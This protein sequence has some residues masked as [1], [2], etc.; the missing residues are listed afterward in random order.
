MPANK[1]KNMPSLQDE[2]S[3]KNVKTEENGNNAILVEEEEEDDDDLPPTLIELSIQDDAK[4]TPSPPIT[5][6]R[7]HPC[8]LTILSGFLGS[9]KTTLIQYILQSP[10]HGKRIAVIENEFGNNNND[11][12]NNNNNA[13]SGLNIESLIAQDGLTQTKHNLLD[14]IELPNGCVCCTIKDKLVQTLEALLQAKPDLDYILLECS[15]MANPGPLATTFW[16][17]EA[18]ESQLRLDGIVTL[19]DAKHIQQQLDTTVEAAQQIAYA[20]RIL[21]NKI[22]LIQE[23]LISVLEERITR[24]NPLAQI[25]KTQYSRVPD[26]EWILDAYLFEPCSEEQILDDTH[27][28]DHSHHHHHHDD[29]EDCSYCQQLHVHTDAISTITLYHDGCMQS[30]EAINRWLAELLWPNQ[31]GTQSIDEPMTIMRIKGIIAFP[32]QDNAKYIVQGVYDTWQVNAAQTA[33]FS[34]NEEK[35]CQLIVIGKHLNESILR[36]G[37]QTCLE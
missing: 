33:Q 12:D 6:T 21:L 2:S 26:L 34:S 25:R 29:E 20:D 5:A 8:P 30:L 15:G 14:M 9:G 10:D 11:D 19:V 22:D 4:D 13:S 16:L 32:G 27:G 37:F 17:D 1:K 35:A 18:L 3:S 31:D 36:Q 23:D 24:L 7:E 28:H